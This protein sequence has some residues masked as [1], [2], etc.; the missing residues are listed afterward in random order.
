MTN[1]SPQSLKNSASMMKSTKRTLIV[2]GLTMVSRLLGFAR[3]AVISAFFG[4]SGMADVLNLTFN[5]PNNFRKLL[6]EGALSAAFIPVLSESIVR[7]DGSPREPRRILRNI[8]SFQ[9]VII[10]PLC[11]MAILFARPLMNGLLADFGDPWKT[12]LAEN[13]FRLFI[14]Y[15]L[16]ISVSAALMGALNSHNRFFFS[17]ASPLLFSICVISSIVFFHSFLGPYAMAVG[18]LLGG[19]AQIL[20]QTPSFLKLGY[21]FKPDFRFNNPA[22]RRILKKWFSVVVTS[23]VFTVT[24]I[25]AYRLAS[26]LEE[27]S[28]SSLSYAVTFWQLPLGIFSASINTVLFPKMSRQASRGE[29]DGL[30]ETLR[31]GLL[32]LAAFLIPSTVFF[33]FFGGETIALALQRGRFTAENTYMTNRALG[34]YAWGL[35]S[36]GVFHLLQRFFYTLKNYRIPFWAALG[37]GILDIGLSLILKETSLRV[38]GLALANSISFSLGALVLVFLARRRLKQIGTANIFLP[39]GKILGSSLVMGLFLFS[40]KVLLGSWTEWRGLEFLVKFLIGALGAGGIILGL[41]RILKLE[42]LNNIFRKKGQS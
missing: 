7:A 36:V 35:F 41:Y 34:A 4:A 1:P 9:L 15:F 32:L 31:H 11:L 21:D 19:M 22:F 28:T 25:V 27:G 26:V 30:G 39:L 37:A 24:Q 29:I 3:I 20:L 14:N 38:A 13:L 40:Y 23:T 16:L 6:A 18:V 42:M 5:I 33:S 17:A 12:K 10:L 8:L 2:S